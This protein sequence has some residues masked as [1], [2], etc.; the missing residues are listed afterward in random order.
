M[1]IA[2]IRESIERDLREPVLHLCHELVDKMA[3]MK[4]DQLNRLTYLTLSSF[5]NKPADDEIFQ[6]ALTALT[7]VNHNPLTLYFLFLDEADD[8]EIAIS[9]AEVMLSV[10]ENFF[11]NPRTGEEIKN[12]VPLLKPVFR[13]TK[14]FIDSLATD[15]R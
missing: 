12:F 4:P 5:V 13:A 1:G 11:V 3:A 9:A 10:D 7:T 2:Q 8:R 14:E 15:G 6:S